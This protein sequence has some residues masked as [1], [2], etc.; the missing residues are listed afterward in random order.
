M[1]AIGGLG[2][3]GVI[4]L[5]L[6]L[7]IKTSFLV[8]SNYVLQVNNGESINLIAKK[9]ERDSVIDSAT[10][11]KV[12]F[13]VHNFF[14][15]CAKVHIGEYELSAG[16]HFI[17]VLDKVCNGH[18][19]QYSITIPEG[20]YTSQIIDIINSTNEL[21]G[22][23]IKDKDVGEG[24]FL[25]ETYNFAKGFNRKELLM[26]MNNDLQSFLDAE[27]QKRDVYIPLKSKYE[28]LILASI[29]EAE[30]KNDSERPIIASVYMNRLRKKMRLQ[31]DPTAIYE[32]TKGKYKMARLL[33]LKDLQIKGEWNTYRKYGLPKTPICNAGKASILAV[34]HPARTDYLY[35]VA[36]KDLSGHIFAKDFQ[37]HFRNKSTTKNS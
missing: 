33:T 13:K 26:K 21:C 28:V 14:N 5:C 8:R 37:E 24:V 4:V 3:V 18:V 1:R 31:A 22:D 15:R 6:F 16:K 36:K 34:L 7:A 23:K 32:I 27:W 2:I 20:L 12:F 35:F 9:L 25:P 17:D 10:L 11:F 30:A 29:V 19:I